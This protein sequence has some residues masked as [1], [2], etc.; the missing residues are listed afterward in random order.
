MKKHLFCII[1]L[2]YILAS[3]FGAQATTIEI[4]PETQE[5][6]PA[7]GLITI[8]VRIEAVTSLFAYQF[9]LTFDNTALRFSAIEEEEFLRSDE[10][11]TFPF[12]TLGEQ[13]VSLE[14]VTPDIAQEVNSAGALV[15]AN[16]RLGSA[17]GIS[18]SSELIIIT[19]E[20][21]EAKA[22]ALELQNVVL[23]DSDAQSIIADV[24]SGAI[25]FTPNVP[26]V[27][28]AG[29]DQAV[30]VGTT[31]SFDGSASRDEDGTIVSYSW[32]FGDGNS[33]MG[34]TI[35][36][37]YGEAGVYE[38]TLIVTDDDGDTGSD[39]LT[40][41]V[42]PPAPSNIPPVAKAGSDRSALIGEEI[43]FDGSASTDADG[44]IASYSWDFGDGNTAAGV[45]ASHIYGDVG[46]Y[47]VTLTVTD[48]DGDSGV[49]TLT[50]NVSEELPPV[51][52]EHSPGSS[53]LVLQA[54]YNEANV[55]GHAYVDIWKG[56][57]PIQAGQF[58][59][60]QVAM[61]SGNPVF[62]GTV[63]LH[64]SD[65]STLRDSVAEDQNDI[66]AHPSAD[67]SEYARDQW[68]HRK[69]SLDA[70]AGKTLDGIMIGTD[71]DEHSAGIFRVYVDNIQ[72]TDGEHILTA[73]YMGE[74][75]IPATGTNTATETTF[76]G[77]GGMSDYSVSIV[78]ATP[79]TPAGKLIS[80]WGG[81]KMGRSIGL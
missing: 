72:I 78:G 22:S 34:V 38:V 67:L 59:E 47:T 56:S 63:D 6:P 36:N 81:I 51:V 80:S 32:N 23:A 75:T 26:P 1:A 73:I 40:V 2:A 46:D 37:V 71:S 8:G 24:S 31:V 19:F 10:T 3:A 17:K 77:A 39:T 15:V 20:V 49:D 57:V 7:G 25:T 45:T 16:T 68:Y 53:M 21:L 29:D 9:E 35:S 76:A 43:S 14:D 65:D 62:S 50:V 27:A 64:T 61:F 42:T 41:A 48:D 13:M 4:N 12:L 79:V 55:H 28:E 5:S 69:I 33:A 60:F 58:L 66:T 74:D 54:T 52:R 30:E 11:A 18:G 70:L 44:T